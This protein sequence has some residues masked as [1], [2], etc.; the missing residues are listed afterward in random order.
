MGS[1][2]DVFTEKDEVRFREFVEDNKKI[3]DGIT[4]EKKK[5]DGVGYEVKYRWGD[6]EY[7]TGYMETPVAACVKYAMHT[8]NHAA[9]VKYYLECSKVR[10][11]L[12]SEKIREVIQED[13]RYGKKIPYKDIVKIL[14]KE[15]KLIVTPYCWESADFTYENKEE[16]DTFTEQ[17]IGNWIK[18]ENINIPDRNTMIQISLLLG[19][20]SEEANELLVCAGYEKMYA[21]SV[22]DVVSMFYLNQ[23]SEKT[24]GNIRK[25][26]RMLEHQLEA[27]SY[28]KESWKSVTDINEEY[29]KG[30]L[31]KV[32]QTMNKG[33]RSCQETE[34]SEYRKMVKLPVLM[35][36][37]IYSK[38][39][40]TEEEKNFFDNEKNIEE[41]NIDEE[42]GQFE[43]ILKNNSPGDIRDL[44]TKLSELRLEWRKSAKKIVRYSAKNIKILG[45]SEKLGWNIQ[46]Q[47]SEM[48]KAIDAKKETY[49]SNYVTSHYEKQ[50]KKCRTEEDLLGYLEAGKVIFAQKQY[51]YLKRTMRYIKETDAYKKNLYFI[52]YSL[53]GN[54]LITE[55]EFLASIP[56]SDKMAE[57]GNIDL[58]DEMLPDTKNDMQSIV[59]IDSLANQFGNTLCKRFCTADGEKSD[60]DCVA[61]LNYIWNLTNVLEDGA[62][63][64]YNS[65]L[66]G[67]K[68]GS[69][70]TVSNGFEGRN[71]L[72]NI[73]LKRLFWE[74]G[75]EEN[76]KTKKVYIFDMSCKSNLIR[77]ALATGKEDE[78]CDY[79]ELA[80][81]WQKKIAD[82]IKVIIQSDG[83]DIL[84]KGIIN[85]IKKENLDFERTFDKLDALIIYVMCYREQL[86]RKWHEEGNWEKGI[87]EIKKQ[88]PTIRLMMLVNRD[89]Q[90][91]LKYVP[92]YM[93]E[94]K[95]ILNK[96]LRNI[97]F[98]VRRS[99]ERWFK[100]CAQKFGVPKSQ[101]EE[102]D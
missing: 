31:K 22:M 78:I 86:I 90:F 42:T 75:N 70:S 5:E 43:L 19:L 45:Y 92:R 36:T 34:N 20:D 99:K 12:L 32:K 46:E 35:T 67:G 10:K 58:E 88:F 7:S 82:W 65:L 95:L 51:G 11:E 9:F 38:D 63:S 69:F 72:D 1:W 87:S 100:G 98:P 40:L 44:N 56:G 61:V 79:L 37:Q 91:V 25:Q 15:W 55:E 26:C 76:A 73:K 83:N 66:Y 17:S 50:F 60:A 4:I 14:K 30:N 102:W 48:V 6:K 62:S 18:E 59:Y 52:N 39:E 97:V 85:R 21:L 68:A 71:V 101:W 96:H 2:K 41:W 89:V 54:Q 64:L 93:L 80:G 29:M 8:G 49:E 84:S 28:N 24:L 33:I 53:E 77:F 27:G 47:Y 74:Q 16:E 57:L 81:F 13:K 94:E 23:F 3:Y